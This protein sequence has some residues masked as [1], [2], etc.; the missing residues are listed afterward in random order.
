MPNLDCYRCGEFGHVAAECP[1]LRPASSL[2]EHQARLAAYRQRFENWLTGEPG[3][4][5]TPEQKARAIAAENRMW[6]PK[7]EGAK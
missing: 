6:P 2:A 7:K 5:W 1:E 4:K 3:M